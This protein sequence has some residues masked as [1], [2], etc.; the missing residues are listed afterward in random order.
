M[1]EFRV[2]TI[3]LSRYLTEQGFRYLRTVQ[4]IKNPHFLNWIFEETPELLKAVQDYQ[5][6]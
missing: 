4:D 5:N 2:Y 1:K 6:K 3:K